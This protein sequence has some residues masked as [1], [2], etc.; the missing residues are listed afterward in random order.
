MLVAVS[1]IRT[2]GPPLCNLS[3]PVTKQRGR[4]GTNICMKTKT[5]SHTEAFTQNP[6][7]C[8]LTKDVHL[9]ANGIRKEGPSLSVPAAWVGVGIQLHPGMLLKTLL[10]LGPAL[11]TRKNALTRVSATLAN[12]PTP[13]PLSPSLLVFC[14][15]GH[16]LPA[17]FC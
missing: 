10:P 15:V 13:S 8:I 2:Q 11:N 3:H 6:G 16:F 12:Q 7:P 4:A 17:F 1:V 5:Q 14:P 9:P